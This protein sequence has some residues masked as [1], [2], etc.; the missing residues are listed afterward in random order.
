MRM[1]EAKTATT[2][3]TYGDRMWELMSYKRGR[4]LVRLDGIFPIEFK[5]V[6]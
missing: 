6:L 3:N 2:S 4:K 5:K 1:R